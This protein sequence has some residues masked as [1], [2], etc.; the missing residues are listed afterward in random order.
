M[1]NNENEKN[2][3]CNKTITIDER[4]YYS[5]STSEEYIYLKEDLLSS[6]NYS[7]TFN[8]KRQ[9]TFDDTFDDR[10]QGT[11]DDRRQGTF[12]DRRQG[13]DKT[14]KKYKNIYCV[15]CGEKGHVVKD[16]SG[17]ITSFG[18]IA[19]KIVNNEKEELNDKNT[20]LQEVISLSKTFTNVN[21]ESYPKIKFL[22]IQRKDTMG[23]TDFVR[24][25]YPEEEKECSKTLP[26]FLNEMTNK[27]K[28]NL[29][30]KTFDEIWG[31]LWVNHDSKCFKNEYELA[32]KK[33]KKLN[34]KELIKKSHSSFE[35]TELG[36]PKG[37]RNMKETNIACAER[38]F[39]EETGY[40]KLCYDFIKNYPT[41]HEEFRGTNGIKYRHIYYLVKM[42]DGI[43]PPKIDYK[44]KIQ[45]GEVQN[46]G[47]LTYEECNSVM[48]P[49]DVAKKRVI[50]K[51]HRDIIEMKNNF[52]CSNFYYT[53]K[54]H[55][56][57]N[58]NTSK[59]TFIYNQKTNFFKN[60]QPKSL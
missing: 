23:F 40:D 3:R 11:F 17:P 44:N 15:N 33:F 42:K 22:M 39:F 25:K 10:R 59:S 56:H 21:D 2:T 43:P 51:V 41:I 31:E 8:D 12:D 18:I 28:H 35:Y 24:G 47:W 7:F 37:R 14:N 9:G 48:R 32:Y 55:F 54:K 58:T 36:F 30:T 50:K 6:Y 34:I 45:T 5:D 26:I 49:Y 29:L 27:E 57:Q 16:C 52:I 4:N 1:S 20:K 53:S 46:I 13:I 38:E 19:F 60:F